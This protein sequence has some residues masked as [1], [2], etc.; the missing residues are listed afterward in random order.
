MNLIFK[1]RNNFKKFNIDGYVVPKND[2]FFSEYSNK[3]RLKKISNFT[4]IYSIK[5]DYMSVIL[6]GLI[7]LFFGSF[8]PYL[9]TAYSNLYYLMCFGIIALLNI[10][11]FLFLTSK[12]EIRHIKNIIL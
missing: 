1:L 11:F 5:F 4:I 3:D 7:V 2:E 12:T 9:G 8:F 6:M 10:I